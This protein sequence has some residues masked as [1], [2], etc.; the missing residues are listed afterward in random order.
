MTPISDQNTADKF[1]KLA[2]RSQFVIHQHENFGEIEN[3]LR[4]EQSRKLALDIMSHRKF[5]ELKIDRDYG[6][7]RADIVVMTNQELAD[8]LREHFHKGVDHAQGYMP[9]WEV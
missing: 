9:K 2:V 6:T 5:F 7:L 1:V 4:V 3:L 8:I